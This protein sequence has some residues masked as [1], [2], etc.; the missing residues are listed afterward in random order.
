ME[1]KSGA[2]ESKYKRR[3][4]SETFEDVYPE[5]TIMDRLHQQKNVSRVNDAIFNGKPEILK[6]YMNLKGQ[7]R[8]RK[9][10][11]NRN[12]HGQ[13]LFHA[14]CAHASKE[15]VS[16]FLEYAEELAIDLNVRSGI[17][18]LTPFM[19][20]PWRKQIIEL[21]LNDQRIEV[22]LKNHKGESLLYNAFM[23]QHA[24]DSSSKMSHEM[25]SGCFFNYVGCKG[26]CD[27]MDKFETLL[28]CQRFDWTTS[29]NNGVTLLH[30]ACAKKC[31]MKVKFLL[32]IASDKGIDVNAKDL[33][34]RTPLHYISHASHFLRYDKSRT[35]NSKQE[36][37]P[38]EELFLKYS[39]KLPINFDAVD[40]NGETF[41]HMTFKHHIQ[42]HVRAFIQ[43]AKDVYKKEFNV[44]LRNHFGLTPLDIAVSKRS[45]F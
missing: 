45:I 9:V 37:F 32:S 19:S 3:K 4:R 16:L 23:V 30:L 8:Q 43:V 29:D 27:D 42:T 38:I 7:R 15:I 14:A 21:L 10:N 13:T 33:H 20:A 41:L 12:L 34:G 5:I 39:T 36:F 26:N 25:S 22:N 40:N 1:D 31:E 17:R 11:F 35:Q 44:S 2:S 6:F 24:S 28:K 18:G